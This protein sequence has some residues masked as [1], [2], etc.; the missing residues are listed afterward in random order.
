MAPAYLNAAAGDGQATL[1]WPASAGATSYVVKQALASSTFFLPIAS[2]VTATN[3]V[4]APLIN[5][6]LYQFIVSGTN[7]FG[8]GLAAMPV[9]VRPVAA[10]APTLGFELLGEQLQFTWLMSHLGWRLEAQTNALGA[11]L[12]DSWVTIPDSQTTNRVTIPVDPAVGS[13]FFR[14]SQD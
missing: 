3:Y 11:G 7:A 6:T 10:T 1:S 8:E 2:G 9:S 12:G 14:L 4:V 13:I 5:G